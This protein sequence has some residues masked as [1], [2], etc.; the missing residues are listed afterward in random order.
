MPVDRP[1]RQSRTPGLL[2]L[3]LVCVIALSGC[4]PPARPEP[5]PTPEPSDTPTLTSTPTPTSTPT[6][7]PTATP[8]PS[9]TSTPLPTS[10]PRPATPTP[11][12]GQTPTPVAINKR[13][14]HLL[15]DDG[16][17]RFPEALW[18]QQIVW[19][20]RLSG[21]GGYAVELVRSDDLKPESW[22]HMIDLMDREGQIPII[23][24][25]TF[26]DEQNQWWTAPPTD[27]DGR[28]YKSA[29]DRYRRFFD[30]IHWRADTVLVTVSNEPNRPDEWGGA[31]SP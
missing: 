20:G 16:N 12:P 29:A 27:P 8:T 1:S 6:V 25:A 3:V 2:V 19:A 28:S 7:P 23:R 9:P 31:P 21:S 5:T 10:T 18:E 24:L 14:V 4:L 11:A 13:G 17:T 30:A 26:K 15:L 22:Q